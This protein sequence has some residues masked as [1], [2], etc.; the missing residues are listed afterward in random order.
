MNIRNDYTHENPNYLGFDEDHNGDWDD[1][2]MCPKCKENN[3]IIKGDD[4]CD[5]CNEPLKWVS[6]NES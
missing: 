2:F 6:P 3:Y 1:F 4:K 5:L